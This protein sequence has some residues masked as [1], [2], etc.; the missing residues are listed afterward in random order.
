MYDVAPDGSL[1]LAESWALG[2]APNSVDTFDGVVAVAVESADK[3]T[4]PGTVE[5]H[6]ADGDG[7]PIEVVTVG[8]LPDMVTFTPDGSKVVVANEGE[9]NSDYTADP[10]GS[11]SVI[12]VADFLDTV[13]RD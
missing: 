11:I 12:D 5:F 6:D 7:T 13:E 9:P 1:A 3:A 4:I 8:Y 10:P 2:G